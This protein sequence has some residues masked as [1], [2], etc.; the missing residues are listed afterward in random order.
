MIPG[1][2]MAPSYLNVDLDILS[3]ARLDPIVN[4]FESAGAVVLVHEKLG[5]GKFFARVETEGESTTPARH[6]SQ[7]CRLLEKAPPALRPLLAK[8]SLTFDVGIASGT[9][10][11]ILQFSLPRSLLSRVNAVS[12]SLAFTVYPYSE[13]RVI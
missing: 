7:L 13:Q 11:P 10:D 9:A 3:R 4:Y 1:L 6:I 8:C 2:A 12:V 5:P